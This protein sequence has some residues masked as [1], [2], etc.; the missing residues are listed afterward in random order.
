MTRKRSG[1][2]RRLEIRSTRFVNVDTVCSCSRHKQCANRGQCQFFEM[3]GGSDQHVIE[4]LKREM[5][6]KFPKEWGRRNLLWRAGSHYNLRW[7]AYRKVGNKLFRRCR[8]VTVEVRTR[9]QGR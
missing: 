8:P 9:C 2:A 4:V 3:A 5:G 1:W 6:D 7:E